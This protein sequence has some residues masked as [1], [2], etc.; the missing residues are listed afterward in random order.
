MIPLV[1]FLLGL[2]NVAVAFQSAMEKQ[3]EKIFPIMANM[4]AGGFCFAIL[5][6]TIF[7]LTK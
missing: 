6:V 5:L 3:K 1:I 7:P 4:F 2:A